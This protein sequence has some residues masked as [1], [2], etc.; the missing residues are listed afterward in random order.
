MT[1]PRILLYDIE[2][3][4]IRAF[5][6]RLWNVDHVTATESDWFI[7]SI[8]WK[9]LGDHSVHVLALD[10]VERL[11]PEDDFLLAVKLQE[12]F[13]DADIVVS[14]NGVQFDQPKARTRML[15]HHLTPPSPFKEVDTLQVARRQF[16]FSS[17]K[18]DDLCQSL[19]IGRKAKHNGFATWQ[20]CLDDDPKAWATMKRYNK[21]DVRLLEKLYLR[22]RPWMTRHPN[23]SMLAEKPE[24][25]PRCQA[26][27][28]QLQRRGWAVRG[29]TRVPRFQCQTCGGWSQGR[30]VDSLRPDVYVG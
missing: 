3:A 8:A 15:V 14:H 4:P 16:A 17:N 24:T 18:L 30:K 2:S 27:A 22:L 19:G 7:L 23:L 28:S 1:Q 6:W 25:C 20:G 9:W 29:V 13:D 21:S 10:D 26:P 11:H 5:V 12:L